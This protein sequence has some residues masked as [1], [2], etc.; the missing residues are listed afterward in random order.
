M[1]S[2]SLVNIPCVTSFG[3][4]WDCPP[5]FNGILLWA[6]L[7]TSNVNSGE[8]CFPFIC[9]SLVNN[10]VTFL[11]RDLSRTVHL[12]LSILSFFSI[13]A[14]FSCSSVTWPFGWVSA[15]PK[16]YC[17]RPTDL[18][19]FLIGLA[20][21]VSCPTTDSSTTSS[22]WNVISE[23]GTKWMAVL[24]IFSGPDS[25]FHP[26]PY[27]VPEMTSFSQMYLHYSLLYYSNSLVWG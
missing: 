25:C 3:A 21:S 24:R 15:F 1:F 7:I 5:C 23:S 17:T 2:F 22:W 11:L 13:S 12:S 9:C 8:T 19:I 27:S 16:S 6:P 20:K 10:S 4:C 26:Q 18:S 14:S